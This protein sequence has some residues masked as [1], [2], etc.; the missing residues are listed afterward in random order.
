M[1]SNV[2][3]D[4]LAKAYGLCEGSFNFVTSLCVFQFHL[5]LDKVEYILLLNR[6]LVLLNMSFPPEQFV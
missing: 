6:V 1:K 2:T 3:K 5:S 4:Y